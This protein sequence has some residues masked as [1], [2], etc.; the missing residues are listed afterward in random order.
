VPIVTQKKPAIPLA[1]MIHIPVRR[2]ITEGLQVSVK[3]GYRLIREKKLKTHNI[4]RRR[5]TTY[6]D[7]QACVQALRGEA[8]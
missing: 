3:K 1:E 4:G 8:R 5:F 7:L 2:G 6:A